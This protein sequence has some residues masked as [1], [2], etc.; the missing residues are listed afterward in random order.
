MKLL[1]PCNH[2][3]A[4]VYLSGCITIYILSFLK[5]IIVIPKVPI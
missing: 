5:M 3:K 1:S 4:D 2:D